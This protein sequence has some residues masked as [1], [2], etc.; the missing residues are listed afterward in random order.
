L[1]IGANVPEIIP[2]IKTRLGKSGQLLVMDPKPETL[3][4]GSDNDIDGSV[5]L[6][7]SATQIPLKDSYVETVL[8]W[9]SF[10]DIDDKKLAVGEFFRVLV[11][12]G[13]VIIGQPGPGAP[14]GRARPCRFGLEHIF[15]QAGF[16]GINF[17]EDEEMFL[18]TADKV[19]GFFSSQ[20]ARA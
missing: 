7:A 15:L 19:T 17:E 13:G 16:N 1:L 3:A 18:F 6:K 2:I 11:G 10:L 8:C 4:F 9:S 20:L 14:I 5:I 12:G